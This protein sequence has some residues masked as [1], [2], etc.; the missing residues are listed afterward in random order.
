MDQKVGYKLVDEA[1]NVIN[2][3]GGV[4][5][6]CPDVPNPLMLPNGDQVCAAEANVSYSG[7]TL[8]DWMMSPEEAPILPVTRRQFYQ[9]CAVEGW[10]TQDSALAAIQSN[11]IP[12]EIESVINSMTDPNQQFQAKMAI[13][14]AL[15][16]DRYDPLLIEIA[17]ALGKTSE[18]VDNLFRNAINI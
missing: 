8:I 17:N 1:G 14:G 5:G 12:P 7:Y 11:T 10:T 15:Q 2:S 3:W 18:E 9:Q 16:Y 6:Q 13:C 4:W